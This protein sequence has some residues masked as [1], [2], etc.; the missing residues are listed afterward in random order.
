MFETIVF[1]T[2][3]R[4]AVLTLNNPVKL[5]AISFTMMDEI[6]AALDQIEIDWNIRALVIQGGERAFCA[7]MDITRDKN[8][9]ITTSPTDNIV[10]RKL[11]T[12]YNRIA[13]LPMAVIAAVSGY[14]LGGGF[15]LA[16]ACDIRIFSESAKVGLPEVNLG[17]IPC[18]GGTQRLS[19]I[20]GAG[21]A[22]ELIMT[23]DRLSAAEAYRL[24]L[25]NH[26]VKPEELSAQAMALAERLAEKAPLAI[27]MAKHAV[28]AGLEVDLDTGL[29]IESRDSLLLKKTQDYLEGAA[30]FREK[31]A[32]NFQG[33]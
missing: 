7:G 4:V 26:V 18:G 12:L 21:T 6:H 29:L 24:G 30:A 10:A 5:N 27:Q 25:A 8:N 9:E 3:G 23:C 33:R 31:R 16:L 28:D 2:R 11:H 15:E 1:E 13:A 19:R 32:P 14:A 20:V 22:K 17:T